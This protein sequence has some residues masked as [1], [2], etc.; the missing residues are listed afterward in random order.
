VAQALTFRQKSESLLNLDACPVK[1]VS[2]QSY[3]PT[4]KPHP[5]HICRLAIAKADT[6]KFSLGT[7]PVINLRVMNDDL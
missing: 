2:S 1:A 3:E 7:K 4:E 5:A 6:S